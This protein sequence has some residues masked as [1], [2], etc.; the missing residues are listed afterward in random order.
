[1]PAP[2]HPFLFG[3][4]LLLAGALALGAALP[5]A[6]AQPVT[7]KAIPHSPADGSVIVAVVNG[8]AISLGDVDSR[9]RLFALST[10]LP[11]TAD[12]LARLTPQVTNQLIDERLRLREMQRRNIVVPDKDIAAA[13]T[14]IETRNGMPPGTLRRRLAADGVALRTMIDQI[15]VQTG[16]G[17]VLREV[18]VA[19]PP[20]SDADIAQ[21]T[22]AL[23]AQIG[24][25]EFRLGEI[26]VPVSN[27]ARI[28]EARR[29]A[30]TIIQQLRAGAP[31]QMVAAQFSQSQTALQGGDQGWVQT[32]EIDPAVLRVLQEMPIGAISNP[33]PV[34]GGLSIVTLRARREIGR[35]QATMVSARQVFFRFATR[36]NQ[37]QPTEAQR[38][39]LEQTR[40]LSTTI[41]TCADMEAAAKAAG[42][43]RGGNP[44]EIRLETVVLPTLK[45]LMGT[46]PIEKVSQ[47]LIAD[48]G[49]ALLM[50]CS[51]ESR[52][53][54]LPSKAELTDRIINERV[55][56]I[57]RQLMRDLQRRAVI[58][59]RS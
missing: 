23:R 1:M 20:I 33:L 3:P 28:D 9:R 42:D 45:Q 37:D 49:V 52:N 4:F 38:Q 31:F 53:A 43:E 26:F 22:E 44:G 14:E 5:S 47:P 13:I 2:L 36:L 35:E 19:Q 40:K 58:D 41:K 55:E 54:D 21:R 11:M 25:T 6:Q 15:R 8:E 50:V 57:S 32:F 24:Q 16:W 59:R 51:R 27:P 46:L 34:A 10:G 17:Q 29:F 18:V 30:D 48:D 39:I 56:M 12:V 7:P